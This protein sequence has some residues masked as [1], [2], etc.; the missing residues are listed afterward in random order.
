MVEEPRAEVLPR[1]LSGDYDDQFSDVAFIAGGKV[2]QLAR[3]RLGTLVDVVVKETPFGCSSPI[4]F[5]EEGGR[6][7]YFLPR[8]GEKGYAVSAPFVNYRANV[9]ALKELGVSR[10]VA[11]SGPGALNPRFRIGQFVLPADLIDLTRHRPTTFFENR[12]IGL[13]RQR[14]V[15]CPSLEGLLRQVLEEL[16]GE[17][18]ESAVYA[19]SEGPRF[20]T[21]A[22]VRM[23]RSMGA[24]LAGMTLA[25]EAFLARELEMCYHPVTYVTAYAE[26]VSEVDADP[27]RVRLEE[28]LERLPEFTSRFLELLP[29]L[30]YACSCQDA[31]LRYKRRGTISDDFHDW[32]E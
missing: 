11:W 13:L 25:P 30:A 32:I 1:I 18:V 15:F 3:H 7:F 19:V 12:G 28:A 10:V 4:L 2:Y 24:D 14:P 17:T 6:R 27:E 16:I 26:G 9:W 23:L 20:E 22:E 29:E 31:M 21:P 8:H 5:M